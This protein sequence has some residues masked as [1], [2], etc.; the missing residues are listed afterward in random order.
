MIPTVSF[1]LH[2]NRRWSRWF[3]ESKVSPTEGTLSRNWQVLYESKRIY[4]NKFS[5]LKQNAIKC[6]FLMWLAYSVTKHFKGIISI[7]INLIF[8]FFFNINRKQWWWQ[9]VLICFAFSIL[10]ICT[11]LKCYINILVKLC[12]S[13]AL[14]MV[15]STVL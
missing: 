6:M 1:G 2:G 5:F 7:V 11:G 14:Q 8:F 12:V 3:S 10:Y 9:Q 15:H 13:V 4:L